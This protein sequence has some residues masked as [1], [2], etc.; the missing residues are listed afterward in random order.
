METISGRITYI[1]IYEEEGGRDWAL[2]LS[3]VFWYL[4]CVLF[5][6]SLFRFLNDYFGLLTAGLGVLILALLIR[7]FGPSNL[8]MLDELLSRIFPSFR[9]AIRLGRIRVHKFRLNTKE[10]RV[11][12][13]IL[14]GALVGAG[15]FTGDTV[16]LEGVSKKGMFHVGR[17]FNEETGSLLGI[18]A[19]RSKWILL[20]TVAIAGLNTLYL[21]GI[22][23]ESIL[24]LI[25][26]FLE[27]VK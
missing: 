27:R 21:A 13:C 1:R 25:E 19:P 3:K 6:I 9:S 17:G 22:F 26:R 7:F 16:T 4:I 12:A 23:D 2:S 24:N 8:V 11:I 5:P 15:P 10:G 20:G 18:K 14:K